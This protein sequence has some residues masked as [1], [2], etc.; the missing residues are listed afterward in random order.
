M[1]SI[2]SKRPYLLDNVEGGVFLQRVSARVRGEE[3]AEYLGAKFNPSDYEGDVCIY[4]KPSHLTHIKDGAYVDLL[5]DIHAFELLKTR[6]GIKVIAMSLVEYEYLKTELSNEIILIPHH[7]I[8]F[9]RVRRER[10]EVTTC[11]YIGAP[12]TYT[13]RINKTV[14]SELAKIELDFIS[15]NAYQTREDIINYYKTVD[16]QILG[17]FDY[18][19]TPYRHPTKI[20]NAASFGIPT[21]AQPISGYKEIEGMYISVNNMEELVNEAEKLKNKQYYDDLSRDI[22]QKT[23]KYHISEIAK[24]YQQLT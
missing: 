5:D 9:E 15:L 20:I 14:K 1:I 6:P 8:N 21:I 19:D 18:F 11:G 2:F 7:H 13:R 16:I 17:H 3:I 24:L 22:I 12:T 23:E 10:K 4:V